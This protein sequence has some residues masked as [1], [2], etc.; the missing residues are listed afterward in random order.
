MI[1]ICKVIGVCV[2]VYCFVFMFVVIEVIMHEGCQN[3]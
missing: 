2:S 1:G 3:S